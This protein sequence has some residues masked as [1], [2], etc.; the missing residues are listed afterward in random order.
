MRKPFI[1][2]NWKMNGSRQSVNI[3]L[4][5]IKSAAIDFNKVDVAV[6]PPFVFLDQVA[7]NLAGTGI[8]WGAQ[9]VSSELAGAFTGEISAAMLLDFSCRYVL[10]GHSERRSLYGEDDDIIAKKFLAAHTAGL[11]P[12]LCVGETQSER[13]NGHTNDVISRQ[14]SVLRPTLMGLSGAIIAYEPV[15]AIG[16][17]QT[18]TPE[19]AQ[20][21][22]AMI[23]E[24]VKNDTMRVLYGGSVKASNAASLFA[25]ADIDG[26]LVGGASLDAA[27][28]GSIVRSICNN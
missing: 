19:Q 3:L 28:F 13:D 4:D 12:I 27:E 9:T 11:Q 18:A 6:F 26:A 8:S 17:G 14:L 23:R 16:T 5:G 1:A 24:Q 10:I 20:A 22:H 7:Q 21:V 15:W 25:M 2:A